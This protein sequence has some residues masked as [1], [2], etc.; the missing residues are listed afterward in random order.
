MQICIFMISWKCL[1]RELAVHVADLKMEGARQARPST[2]VP[3][4]TDLIQEILQQQQQQKGAALSAANKAA[5]S[6]GVT[7][8]HGVALYHSSREEQP[9]IWLKWESIT[10][11]YKDHMLPFLFK[12][13]IIM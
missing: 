3:L 2:V 10:V 1:Q 13:S 7:A 11:K 9:S 6:Q 12:Y 4:T 5:A 8:P